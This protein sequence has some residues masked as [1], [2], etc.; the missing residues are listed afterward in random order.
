MVGIRRAEQLDVPALL[1]IY[2]HYVVNTPVTFDVTPRSLHQRQQWMEQFGE[3]GRYRCFVATEGEQLVGWS[4]STRFKEREAYS[5]SVETSVYCHPRYTGRG[6]GR[7][8]YTV[9][10]DALRQEN[11]H[12]AYA[13]ITQP[14]EASDRLHCALGFSR[15]GMYNEVGQKFGRFWDVALYELR[16]APRAP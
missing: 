16:M 10:F 15:I 6:I 3:T 5:T 14:N 7:E 12:R 11:I 1:D 2:N 9:L 4:C 8:L 13:G